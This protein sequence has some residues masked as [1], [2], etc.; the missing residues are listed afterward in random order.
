MFWHRL[1]QGFSCSVTLA[2]PY[3]QQRESGYV[4]SDRQTTKESVLQQPC[5]SHLLRSEECSEQMATIQLV[6]S[7]VHLCATTSP[8]NSCVCRASQLKI[9]TV[10]HLNALKIGYHWGTSFSHLLQD[11]AESQA[12]MPH[13]YEPRN[14]GDNIALIGAGDANCFGRRLRDAS[15]LIAEL[16]ASKAHGSSNQCWLINP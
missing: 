13:L 15:S 3:C 12:S 14:R 5:N 8:D 2:H 6:C 9:A 4:N 7:P 1:K 10:M 16:N 11:A